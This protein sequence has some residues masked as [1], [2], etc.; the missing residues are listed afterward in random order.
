MVHMQLGCFGS[1]LAFDEGGSTCQSCEALE[2][3]RKIVAKRRPAF[4]KFLDNYR[5]GSGKLVSERWLTK[6][7]KKE[8]RKEGSMAYLATVY[9]SKAEFD[10]IYAQSDRDGKSVIRSL[11]DAREAVTTVSPSSIEEIEPTFAM[12]LNEL[13]LRGRLSLDDIVGIVLLGRRR[14]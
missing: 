1:S 14:R 13:E 9:G 10:R 7:E 2:A 4:I 6:Q 11:A 12:V 3:C 5:D 8:R